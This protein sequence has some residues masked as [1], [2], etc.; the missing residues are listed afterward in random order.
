VADAYALDTR[1]ARSQ[2]FKDGGLAH[3]IQETRESL[4]RSLFVLVGLRESS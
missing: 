4:I 2:I 1:N 3:G